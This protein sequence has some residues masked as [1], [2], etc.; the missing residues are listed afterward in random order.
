MKAS[1]LG[2]LVTV[3]LFASSCGGPKGVA[4]ARLST[5]NEK[6][7][8]VFVSETVHGT[9]YVENVGSDP[10]RI[11]SVKSLCVCT[12]P[13]ETNERVAPGGRAAIHYEMVTATA[14]E[15]SVGILVQTSPPLP[16]PLRFTAGGT[17][18]PVLEVGAGEPEIVVE[19]GEPFE[20]EIA[21]R[22]AEGAGPLRVT[23]GKARQDWADVALAESGAGELPRLVFRSREIVQ[24]G[25]HDLPVALEFE[26]QE[27]GRQDTTVKIRVQSDITIAPERLVVELAPGEARPTVELT[28]KS[29]SGKP[30]LPQSIRAQNFE[31]VPQTLPDAAAPSHTIPITL[32]LPT[33]SIPRVG[34]IF[35]DPGDGKGERS[36]D[37]FFSK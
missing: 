1:A 23:G 15:K 31:V 27:P 35:V 7:E 10:F 20:R 26:R 11:D 6:H 17:W 16:E 24:P 12:T 36:V 34:R 8:P 9:F 13:T 18:K 30:F 37:V 33:D 22:V 14:R 19:F 4:V 29:E 32:D 5:D 28:V 2:G 21:L 3:V 25:T